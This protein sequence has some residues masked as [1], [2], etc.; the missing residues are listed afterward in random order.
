MTKQVIVYK[1]RTVVLH[2]SLGYDVSGDEFTSE[3]RVDK[4][5]TSQLIATW[6]VSFET[7]GVDGEL[8]LRLD[9]AVTKL[10]TKSTGYMDVKRVSGGE[11]IAVFDEPLEVLF[12]DTVTE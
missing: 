10:I 9:D 3:I 5:P 2:V 11:P 8:V 7:D 1:N 6:D 4:D 12:K